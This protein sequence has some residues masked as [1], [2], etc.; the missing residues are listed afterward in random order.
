MINLNYMKNLLSVF[1]LIFLTS[2]SSINIFEDNKFFYK[3]GYQ[4]VQLESEDNRI[5]NIHPI[6]INQNSLEGALKL[7]L[8]TYG[9]KPQALF[10]DDR[11]YSYSKAISEALKEAKPDEDVV[12]TLEG[13]YKQKGLSANKVTSGRI[14][15]NKSGLNLIFGSILRQGNISETD[16]MLSAGINPN[17]KNNPYAPGSRFQTINNKYRLSA[18]PNSGVFRPAAAKNRQ[19]WLV[20][21]TKALRPRASLTKQ[22]QTIA[23]RSNIGVEQLKKELQDLRRELRSVRSPYQ[24]N[25]GYYPSPNQ[26]YG[27]PHIQRPYDINNQAP[28]PNNYPMPRPPLNNTGYY[29]QNQV[30]LEPN[31]N[32]PNNQ[33]SVKSLESMRERGLI[34]EENYFKKL[35]ELGY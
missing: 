10:P 20:F 8:T 19:D 4:R 7:I 13:W 28:Y 1:F 27:A 2:C 11:V 30:I 3:S 32:I 22:E 26:Q 5:K 29:Q 25:R 34:S 15:Y 35:K 23:L 33:V 21:S 9:G 24:Q 12:F 31:N 16:P 14:F 6:N 17:L 18:L